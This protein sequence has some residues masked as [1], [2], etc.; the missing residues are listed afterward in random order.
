MILKTLI[1]LIPQLLLINA[2][3]FPFNRVALKQYGKNTVN[4]FEPPRRF[5][6][7]YI[8]EFEPC[9]F[10]TGGNSDIPCEIYSSF[11][12]KLAKE[13]LTVLVL[14][15]EIKNNYPLLREISEN[16]PVTVIGHSSGCMEALD[17]CNNLD[18]VKNII[19][20][21]PVDNRIL[22]DRENYN[23]KIDLNYPSNNT[24]F[25]NARKSY[26]W[27]FFPPKAPFIPFFQFKSDKLNLENIKTMTAKDFGHADILD[28][29]WGEI[30]HNSFA[31]GLE[32]RDV[33]KI[34]TYHTW[35]ASVIKHFI[36][37]GEKLDLKT[38]NWTHRER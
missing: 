18:T 21:D 25:L 2:F 38:V 20:L 1:F 26:K 12:T 27:E 8:E 30:M 33:S 14:N 34:D 5:D 23:S 4:I 15:S 29:K 37:S 22:F 13:N 36:K 32:D 19:L 6:S 16:K 17:A 10:Y 31:K 9:L 3:S 35:V 24:L 28:Y 11:L 7:N